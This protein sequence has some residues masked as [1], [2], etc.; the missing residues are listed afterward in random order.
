MTWDFMYSPEND[1]MMVTASGTMDLNQIKQMIS[2]ALAGV[3]KKDIHKILVD[4]RNMIPD[5]STLEIYN[6]PSFI[7]NT[8]HGQ[9]AFLAVVYTPSS[10]KASDFHFFTTH[11]QVMGFSLTSSQNLPRL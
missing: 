8:F 6:L 11:R 1:V 10:M 7:R 2:D 3:V 9:N 5:V 4:T